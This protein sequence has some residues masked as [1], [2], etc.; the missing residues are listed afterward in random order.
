[1][2]AHICVNKTGHFVISANDLSVCIIELLF[3][4]LAICGSY[5][6]FYVW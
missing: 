4:V 2:W 6:K 5:C 3:S 1:M